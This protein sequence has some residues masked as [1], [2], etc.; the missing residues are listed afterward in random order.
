MRIHS[1]TPPDLENVSKRHVRIPFTDCLNLAQPLT[2]QFRKQGCSICLVLFM[3]C[4]QCTFT[5][6]ID[7]IEKQAK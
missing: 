3:G 4:E 1:H 2:C 5:L 6:G 7:L